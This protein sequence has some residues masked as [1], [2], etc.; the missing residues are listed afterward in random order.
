MYEMSAS[1]R[2]LLWLGAIVTGPVALTVVLTGTIWAI[3]AGFPVALVVGI[4]AIAL[5]LLMAWSSLQMLTRTVRKVTVRREGVVIVTLLGC[6]T[7]I[8]WQEVRRVEGFAVS[9]R[10][11][12]I[13]GVRI[14][15]GDEQAFVITNRVHRFDELLTTILDR[16]DDRRGPWS[17]RV[18]ERVL[19]ATYTSGG[20]R[21]SS[22][23]FWAQLSR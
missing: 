3:L 2:W 11:G 16:V 14:L 12:W 8:P 1:Y 9:L 23:R 13:R 17:P 6:N 4:P 20:A 21:R 18:W 10:E 19:F 7:H 5:A 22:D 15:A